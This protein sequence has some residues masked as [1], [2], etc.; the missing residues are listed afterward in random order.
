MTSPWLYLETI[1]YLKLQQIGGRLWHRFYQPKPD[2]RAAPSLRTIPGT[3]VAGAS[4]KACMID[5]ATVCFLNQKA[6]ISAPE[7]WEDESKSRLWLYNLHYFD[8]LNA[9]GAEDRLAW[10]RNLIRRWIT[11]NPPAVGTGWESY[12]ISLRIVN[13]VKWHLSHG[14]LD[15][16]AIHSLAV[17]AR[18]LARRL[19]YHILGNHL[20]ANAKALLFAGAVFDGTEG[21]AWLK[22]GL[23]LMAREI[24]RQVLPDGGHFELSPMYHLIVLEDLLDCY[25]LCQTCE[26]EPPAGL[27]GAI[28]RML[29]W[30][31]VMRHPDGEI[32]F[33][34]DAALDIAAPPYAL[35]DYARRLGFISDTENEVCIKHLTSSGYARLKAGEATLFADMAPVG[36]D[37]L[38]GHAHADT[39]SFELSLGR[40]RF[41]VN[42]GTSIYEAGTERQRQRGTAAHSTV[43]IDGQDSSRV[44]AAFRVGRR[45]RILDAEA[46][47]E[48]GT[49]IAVGAHDGYRFMQGRPIHRRTWRLAPDAL[50]IED[51]IEGS[52]K[53]HLE[54]LFHLHPDVVATHEGRHIVLSLQGQELVTFTPPPHVETE[55]REDSWHPAFG[56]AIKSHSIRVYTTVNL[57][58]TLVTRF[59]WQEVE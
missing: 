31:R 43:V 16:E 29:N 38:P 15:S 41:I 17:Q 25:N 46:S 9:E 35:D 39:L 32:P 24:E 1:R 53:H 3:W 6:D 21:A 34:N 18:H 14:E 49:A 40:S 56:V 19:E 58:I 10:H 57:P 30:S 8:D 54:I 36:P 52:K 50:E 27:N 42:S 23:R 7:C 51:S 28:E 59:A 45:A 12:P 2:N 47:S 5:S 20:L 44:W 11:E 55:L 33:F 37:H 26:I 4:R 13:W 22:K 48:N